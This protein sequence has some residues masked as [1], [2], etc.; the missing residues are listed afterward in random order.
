MYEQLDRW[1]EQHSEEL[2]EDLKTLVAFDSVAVPTEG[3]HPYGDAVA[4][5]LDATLALAAKAGMRT[6]NFGYHAGTIDLTD[7]EP[8][9]GIL[10]HLDVVPAPADGWDT[11]PFTLTVKHGNA[12]GRGAID[13]KG[14][15]LAVLYAMRAIKELGLPLKHNVRLIAGCCEE[16]G[17][18]DMVYYQQ[19][20]A[21]P[22]MLFTPDGNFPVINI[23]KG[24]LP[25]YFS[26]KL[27]PISDKAGIV[28]VNAG[29]VINAVP[30]EATAVLR[31]Y[32]P[33]AVDALTRDA[34]LDGIRWVLTEGKDLTLT[35][36]GA[37]AHGST[38][39]KGCNALTALLSV[40]AKLEGDHE[41]LRALSR[42]FPHGD[43]SGVAAGIAC[44]DEVSG[45]LTASLDIC[46]L[47]ADGSLEAAM[48]CRFPV[49]ETADG[50][51]A[52]LRLNAEAEGLAC[53]SDGVEPHYVDSDSHFVQTL[54]RVY[55][56]Q[57]GLSGECLAIGGGTYVH[58][59][60]NGVAFGPEFPGEEY[61]MHAPN[62][63]IPL[64]TLRRCASIYAHAILALCND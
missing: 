39:D 13:D 59:T 21:F 34:A 56:Q 25:S 48:D 49:S 41:P 47:S 31:G 8:A 3:E 45:P 35:A 19:Q 15:T 5:C 43:H 18:A 53:R 11:P 38:P 37:A 9:L 30:A 61:H 12:Y 58:D 22:P 54:L 44:R 20:Q 57:T 29:S 26:A 7:G 23:E 1:L 6:R 27:P 28:S 42:L 33:A 40:L 4:A 64:E 63:F 24:R 62:E 52:T 51:A 2:I 46:R 36:I 16:I 14:P 10:G 17:G 55:E 60:E 50:L 32:E